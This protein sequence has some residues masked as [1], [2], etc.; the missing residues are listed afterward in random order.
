MI[1]NNN[2]PFVYLHQRSAPS[3]SS[4]QRIADN[5]FM[6]AQLLIFDDGQGQFGPLMDLRAVFEFRSGA[7]TA[8]SR[9]ERSLGQPAVALHVKKAQIPAISHR[10]A[11]QINQPLGDGDWLL[12]N[13]RWLGLLGADHVRALAPGSALLQHDGQLVAAHLPADLAQQVIDAAFNVP[14]SIATTT[15]PA[16]SLIRDASQGEGTG[17]DLM[18]IERPWHLLDQ[19]E[20]N[21]RDDLDAFNHPIFAPPSLAQIAITGS[22]PCKVAV[23]AKVSPMVVLNADKGPIVID[24]GAQINSFAVIN[25]PC[26]I[27]Q[28]STVNAHSDIRANTV[29]GPACKVGGEISFSI[30]HGYTNKSHLGYLGHSLVGAW[31]NFGAGSTVSN[32]KNTYGSIRVQLEHNAPAQDTDRIFMGPIIGDYTLT[33]IGSRIMT[34]SCIGTGTM[35]ATSAFSPKIAERFSFITDE[36]TQRYDIDKF[37][38]MARRMTS[39]RGR[40]IKQAEEQLLRHIYADATAMGA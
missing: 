18:L 15:L 31:V 27:G 35:L 28:R 12:V 30:I 37:I 9:I 7:V 14:S 40:A 36:T 6:S 20:A 1:N 33:A 17:G 38:S 16:P 4:H 3:L 39:R 29:I 25:G 21:L 32:L 2:P 22:H 10:R 8:L 34:G 5:T 19:L 24:S 23:D 13:G 26:Y 11:S